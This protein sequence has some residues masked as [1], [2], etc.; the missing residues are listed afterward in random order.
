C[1]VFN[2][3]SSTSSKREVRDKN[4]IVESQSPAGPRKRV[5]VLP[6]LDSHEHPEGFR[7]ESQIRMIEEI[8]RNGVMKAFLVSPTD[9]KNCSVVNLEYDFRSCSSEAQKLGYQALFEGRIVKLEVRRGEDPVGLVRKVRTVVEAT[10]RLRVYNPRTQKEIFN[11]D[12]MVTTTF[13]DTKFGTRMTTDQ[14]VNNNP[15]VLE[16]IIVDGFLEFLP[17]I[18]KKLVQVAW[19]GRIAAIQGQK[20]YLNVGSLSGVQVGDLLRVVEE[21]PSIYDPQMGTA[22]GQAPGRDKGTLEVISFF[23]NDGA[24]AIL[25]SGGGFLEND[26]I[27]IY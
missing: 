4:L 7:L 24:I 20:F 16:K 26:R 19:E 13:E 12:K 22:I 5:A 9:L 27:E 1:T 18:E 10:L 11:T 15:Q 6:F 3:G 8:N 23:G 21:G 14:L 17:Q 2:S 25:H